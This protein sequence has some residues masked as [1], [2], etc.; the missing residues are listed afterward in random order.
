MEAKCDNL[1]KEN[2]NYASKMIQYQKMES[3]LV[4]LQKANERLTTE[5]STFTTKH[6][7]KES[8]MEV[9]VNQSKIQQQQYQELNQTIQVLKD[10]KL[11]LKNQESIIKKEMTK[12]YKIN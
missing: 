5:I 12:L 8:E 4:K 6:T 9:M 10:E 7:E 3:Q 11:V 2:N 1:Q